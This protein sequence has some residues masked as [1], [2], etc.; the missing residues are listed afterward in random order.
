MPATTVIEDVNH[1]LSQLPA[2]KSYQFTEQYLQVDIEQIEQALSIREGRGKKYLYLKRIFDDERLVER[3]FRDLANRPDITFQSPV[4]LEHWKRYLYDDTCILAQKAPEQYNSAIESQSRLCEQIFVRPICVVS[5]EAGT[6]KTTIISAMIKAIEKAHRTGTSF[7]LLAQTG[8]AVDRIRDRVGKDATTI[9][10]FLAERDWLNDNL[11]F[12]RTGGRRE[13]KT[14]TFIIDE[15]SMVNLELIA[16]LFRAINFRAVQRLI[17]VGDPNQLPPI[18]RGRVMSDLIEWMTDKSPEGIGR[19]GI[20]VRQM[21]GRATDQGTGILDLAS[22]YVRPDGLTDRSKGATPPA[23][24][25]LRKVQE[26]GDVYPDLRVIYWK[27]PEDLASKLRTTLVADLEV[28]TG[29]T[30]DPS[31]PFELWRHAFNGQPE[32]YQVVSP[33]RGEQFGTEHLNVVL[34]ESVHGKPLEHGRNVGGIALFDK[35]IQVINRPKSNR[36]E[37]YNL[38]T[39]KIE[40]IVVYNGE[41]GF[42][43]PHG[44]DG[45]KWKYPSSQI[46]RFQAVFSRKAGYWVNY[47]SESEVTGNLDSPT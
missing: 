31:K 10:S 25:I 24:V 17:I 37:A 11:T 41:L 2:W 32:K 7:Q 15:A 28:D 46:R 44:L 26:G 35:V 19:L 13:E 43:K 23:E 47:N 42:T 9:H 5:G 40:K 8:K 39:R 6:G 33:Y 36:A 45:Q 12:R 16:A 38:N 4:T 3:V 34:Q 27:G 22:L 20:N 14:S 21:E 29:R 1:R 30:L 18:G